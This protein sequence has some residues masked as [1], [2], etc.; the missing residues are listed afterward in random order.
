MIGKVFLTAKTFGETCEYLKREQSMSQV[1]AVEGVRGHDPKLMAEDFERQ[2]RLMPEK[3]KPVFHGALAFPPEERVEDARLV[4][5]AKEYLRRIG[6]VNT[7]Y[8]LVK[9]TDKEHLHVHV[10]ANRVNNDGEPIGKGLIIERSMKAAA[11]LTMEYGLQQEQG[12]R[13][14]RTNMEA[15][16]GPDARRYRIYTAIRDVL[17]EC[18]NLDQL[19]ARL[20]EQG[21]AVR[22]RLDP[23]TNER[24]GISFRYGNMSFKGSRVDA[25]FSLKG[26]DR[27]LDLQERQVRQLRV[28]ES[29]LEEL[30]NGRPV[31]WDEEESARRRQD[32]KLRIERTEEERLH[33]GQERRLKPGEEERLEQ[34]IVQEQVQRRGLR[35]RL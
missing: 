21:I 34:D 17:P 6:M 13:L 23:E 18:L 22:Y 24:Q 20:Q 11:E 12:K 15:L 3:E 31:G 26:L 5:I 9:H 8:A 30:V 4:E 2:H 25:E 1:L 10:L 16:H 35:M 33:P 14:E 7:Q 27:T 28:L 32:L 19:E 29:T